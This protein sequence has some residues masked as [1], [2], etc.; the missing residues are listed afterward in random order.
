MIGGM[1]LLDPPQAKYFCNPPAPVIARVGR[2]QSLRLFHTSLPKSVTQFT[3]GHQY[4]QVH[5]VNLL[6][7]IDR[8]LLF[9]VSH[10]RR[11]MDMLVPAS[12]PW[13]QV[14][15]YYASFYAANAILG[16]FG[17][18]IGH[19]KDGVRIVDIEHGAE[20]T[21]QLRIHRSPKSP[22]GVNGSHQMFWDFFY[23]SAAS[24]SGWAPAGLKSALIPVNGDFKWQIVERNGVNYDMYLAWDAAMRLNRTFKPHRL[25]S[26]NGPLQQQLET[27]ETLIKLALHFGVKLK[28]ST[29]GLEGCGHVGPASR[30]RRRLG[31]QRPP[32][33]VMQSEFLEFL[34]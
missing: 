13:A 1:R 27:T 11:A 10:Y 26:L 6:I 9:S 23:F 7:E 17:G 4:F 30:I 18:W 34:A 25:N 3:E 5:Q 22:R 12:A 20:G 15:L 8:W 19:S 16:M 21:Q 33:I 2:P 32:Q 31:A 24:I 28:L 29:T 14:T